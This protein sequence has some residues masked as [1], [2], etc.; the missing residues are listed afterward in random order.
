MKRLLIYI[1]LLFASIPLAAQNL[2]PTVSVTREFEGKSLDALKP[3]FAMT[4]PDSL[5]RFD[6]DFDYSALESRYRGGVK[7]EPLLQDL[8]VEGSEA[9]FSKLFLNIGAGYGLHPEFDLQWAP[10]S[11]ERLTVN[12]YGSHR[13]YYGNFRNIGLDGGVLRK[14]SGEPEKGF[15]MSNRAGGDLRFDWKKGTLY[16][17]LG[18]DGFVSN[19]WRIRNRSNAANASL[20]LLSKGTK[21]YYDVKFGYRYAGLGLAAKGIAG[22]ALNDGAAAKGIANQARNDVSN[23]NEHRFL[24]DATL[25][26]V[27]SDHHAVLVDVKFDI[28]SYSPS[29]GAA[30]VSLAPQ[31]RFWKGRWNIALGAGF[32]FLINPYDGSVNLSRGQL[33]Y[34]KASIEF[35]AIRDYLNIYAKA[36]G[37]TKMNSYSDLFALSHAL[38]AVPDNTVERYR[39]ELG[40]RGNIARVLSFNLRGGWADF[41]SAPLFGVTGNMDLAL[42]YKSLATPF[43]ALDLGLKTERVNANAS[44]CWRN[45]RFVGS[46]KTAP[47]GFLPSPLV[48]NIDV[49]YNYRHRIFASISLDAALGSKGWIGSE[50][51][52]LPGYLDLCAG[53]RYAHTSHLSFYL[54]GG[55]LAA[56]TLQRV[57]LYAEAGPYFTAGVTLNF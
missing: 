34:P 8:S 51:V 52:R 11:K 9:K 28:A 54:K 12:V 37:G 24:F 49:C 7:V 36:D 50:S 15:D 40:L 32:E 2:D 30:L 35:T 16:F 1:P 14:T 3:T 53:V 56:M 46:D 20:R 27:L 57:P 47:E 19:D 23:I 25:G 6:L 4:V 38:V 5:L 26:P 31:Y 33:V 41:S 22:G 29:D 44:V 48:G 18:Y 55:N 13:S 39:V 21:F 10:V 17:D 43:A 42:Y 45:A